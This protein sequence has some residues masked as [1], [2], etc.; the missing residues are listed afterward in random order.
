MFDAVGKT[1]CFLCSEIAD[2]LPTQ[3]QS[4]VTHLYCKNCGE[5]NITI[6]AELDLE[7]CQNDIKYILSSQTFEKYY[8]EQEPLT[9]LSEHINNAKDIPLLE[10]L[11]KLSKYLYHETKKIGL[12]S[13]IDGIG[14]SQFYCRNDDEFIQLLETLKSNNIID[15]V[16]KRGTIADIRPYIYLP[17][18]LGN[19][20]LV[21]EE[22]IDNIEDFK[23][24]F[25][26]T[27]NDR[28][29]FNINF[30][31]EKNQ[32][33]LATNDSKITASQNNFLDIAELN[34]LI[35]NAVKSLPQNISDE[36]RKE[37]TEN[38]EFI[39]TEIQNSNPRKTIIKNTLSVLKATVAT[40]GFLASLAKI[41]EFL[42]IK[43]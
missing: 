5:Y 34:T 30:Q 22:G 6:Q 11:F 9:I 24:A 1:K 18:L 8:Y 3:S 38:L 29:Q 37:I 7:S 26:N 36:K 41:A 16:K 15:I 23:K 27:K 2:V 35:E 25:M 40:A 12:G 33:N 21:F 4:A 10:K 13:K 43:F 42:G 19:A 28:N 17:I 31:G 39:K 14:Y 20:M 32:F